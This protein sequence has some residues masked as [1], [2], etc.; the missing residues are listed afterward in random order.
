MFNHNAVHIITQH[1]STRVFG[2]AVHNQ[3]APPIPLS[4]VQQSQ[5]EVAH[6]AWSCK[7]KHTSHLLGL[8]RD[9]EEAEVAEGA[10]TGLKNSVI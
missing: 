9:E 3:A 8:G 2:R 7:T 5:H 10:V 4:T 1:P 6:Q